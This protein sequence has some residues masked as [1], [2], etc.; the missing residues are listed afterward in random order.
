MF[1]NELFLVAD[2][3]FVENIFSKILRR[4]PIFREYVS[5]IERCLR[6]LVTWLFLRFLLRV[7]FDFSVKMSY[8]F[9]G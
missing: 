2:K 8:Q 9:F 1:M 6:V 4:L 3:L 7:G 5:F